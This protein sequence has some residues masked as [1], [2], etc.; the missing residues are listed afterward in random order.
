MS[1]G[2]TNSHMDT[3]FLFLSC[4]HSRRQWKGFRRATMELWLKVRKPPSSQKLQAQGESHYSLSTCP[5]PQTQWQTPS[6]FKLK[7]NKATVICSLLSPL[8]SY[9]WCGKCG[10]ET[11]SQTLE[12]WELSCEYGFFPCLLSVGKNMGSPPRENIPEHLRKGRTDT[13]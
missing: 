8:S 11:S 3:C 9:P 1:S 5:S 4:F 10:N 6:Y 13:E 2:L 12:D 7:T